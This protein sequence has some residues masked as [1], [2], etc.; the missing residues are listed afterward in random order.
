MRLSLLSLPSSLLLYLTTSVSASSP[1]SQPSPRAPGDDDLICPTTSSLECYPRVFNPTAEFQVVQPDQSIPP[2]LH[3]RLNLE[4]GQKEARLNIPLGDTSDGEPDTQAIIVVPNETASDGVN[5]GDANNSNELPLPRDQAGNPPPPYSPHGR[6]PQ[7]QDPTSMTTFH[8]SISTILS[9]ASSSTSPDALISALDDLEDIAH[10]MYYG[11]EIAKNRT[12]ASTLLD[13]MT[14]R[15]ATFTEQEGEGGEEAARI[16]ALAALVLGNAVQNNPVALGELETHDLNVTGRVMERLK[17]TL[18]TD[19]VKGG[20]SVAPPAPAA[21]KLQER[22][23]Y[24]LGRLIQNDQNRALFIETDGLDALLRLF[25]PAN[26]G[27]DG[28]DALRTKLAGFMTDNFLTNHLD[29]D[30]DADGWGTAGWQ[31]HALGGAEMG[32][33]REDLNDWC[34]AYRTVFESE[35][36]SQLEPG[37]LEAFVVAGITSPLCSPPME[38]REI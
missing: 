29:V 10:D 9:S 22:L 34:R 36:F 15:P 3:I 18:G 19:T 2:G 5:N 30:P 1:P 16:S 6:I 27:K 7:P 11:V 37:G 23:V 25:D 31:Q 26:L 35:G 4:T 14:F 20:D 33:A 21:L 13:L 28:R 8:T 24:V 17:E 38:S 12:L 32:A